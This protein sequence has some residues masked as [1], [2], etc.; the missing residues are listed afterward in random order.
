MCD[1]D[2][3]IALASEAHMGQVDKAGQPYILHPLRL[4][5]QFTNEP[6]RIVAILHDVV[7]DSHL[8][9]NDLKKNN[10]SKEIIDAIDC[11]SKRNN[12]H[13]ND[14]ILRVSLN[15]LARKI[16]I[17]DLKDNLDLTRLSK[18]SSSDLIR[19]EKY[20]MAL[21]LLEKYRQEDP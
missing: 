6:D 13:Y 10:F 18:I 9:L 1:I 15:D 11:L 5:S 7:E 4:M 17:K 12:E 20:H 2:C 3:A 16:K 19:V 21:K 14:Y 8:R